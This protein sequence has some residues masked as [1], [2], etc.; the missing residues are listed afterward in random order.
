MVINLTN[1]QWI[2]IMRVGPKKLITHRMIY[3]PSNKTESPPKN[4]TIAENT[5][6]N[7]FHIK[8]NRSTTFFLSLAWSFILMPNEVKP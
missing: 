5:H 2:T 4:I 3:N 7:Q 8:H 6:N 1:K